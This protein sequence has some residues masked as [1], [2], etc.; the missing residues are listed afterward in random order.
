VTGRPSKY[1]ATVAQEIADAIREGSTQ[2]D[3]ARLAGI[4]RKTF[5]EWMNQ[6]SKR[7]FR[8]MVEKAH[9]DFKK[10][11]IKS[12]RAAGFKV[13]PDGTLHGSWQANAWLLE[14]KYPEDFG[15]RLTIKLSPEQFAVLQR[16]GLTPM[17]AIEQLVNALDEDDANA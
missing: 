5:Y 11:Q 15:Q 3:A 6:E 1:S 8:D 14:R 17:K 16:H 7:D 13:M 2:D 4:S 10:T 12:I 9:A